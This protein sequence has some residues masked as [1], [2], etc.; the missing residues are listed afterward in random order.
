VIGA[1]VA[2]RRM[3]PSRR[4]MLTAAAMFALLEIAAGAMPTYDLFLVLLVPTGIA[5]MTFTVAAN[6]TMQIGIAPEMRGRVMGLYMLVFLGTNP[7]GAPAI[8]WL[9]EVLGPR[10]GLIAGGA[11]SL[12]AVLVVVAVVMFRPDPRPSVAP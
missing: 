1:L 9:A 7:F 10:S 2:A 4:L 3:K 12:A 11:V 8:G 6:A 5:L